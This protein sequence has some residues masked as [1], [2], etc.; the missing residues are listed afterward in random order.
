MKIYHNVFNFENIIKHC[1]EDNETNFIFN[2]KQ[3]N[4]Y[5]QAKDLI[6]YSQMLEMKMIVF[7]DAENN[8]N[9]E[10]DDMLFYD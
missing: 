10:E 7:V 6:E 8:E 4:Y 3:D 9:K 2:L 1:V 5:E